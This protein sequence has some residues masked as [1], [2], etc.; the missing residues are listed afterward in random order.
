VEAGATVDQDTACVVAQ[1]PDFLGGIAGL[2]ALAA[3]AHAAGALLVVA[4]NLTALGMLT[5]P[6][7]MGADIVVA[8]GQPLGQ[9]TVFGGPYVGVYCC[10]EAYVRQ[11]P[12][13][14]VGRTTDA[15]GRTGYVLTLQA[16]EQH[17]RRERATSNICTSEALVALGSTI[18]LAWMGPQ[19]LR[20]VAEL[21]YH[22]AHYLAGRIAS[23]AGFDLMNDGE[24]FH[25]FVVRCPLTPAEVNRRLLETGILGGLDVSDL[26][27]NGWL[28]CCTEVTT[29]DDMD[30]LVGELAGM[31]PA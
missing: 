18:Y 11:M 7:A 30:R 6:G 2:A 31:V 4:V 23:L 20:E 29:R 24:F 19:G 5:P 9:S 26:V 10:R 17:I 22:K 1:Y 3:A 15:Q 12:G 13:R 28:L 21:C 8:E 27:P 14:I 25:E 16:R